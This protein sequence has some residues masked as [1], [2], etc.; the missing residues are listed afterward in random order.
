MRSMPLL[1]A[2]LFAVGA[3]A[4]SDRDRTDPALDPAPGASASPDG[5]VATT[6]EA[7]NDPYPASADPSMPPADG[8]LPPGCEGEAAQKD[9]ACRQAPV[10]PTGTTPS[11]TDPAAPAQPTP[12]QPATETPP[13]R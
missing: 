6:P 5:R 11:P 3:T 7:A 10:D 4:C 2:A 9:P 13:V 1:M 12:T 8:S